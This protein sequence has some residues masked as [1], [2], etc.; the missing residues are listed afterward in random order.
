MGDVLQD[1]ILSGIDIVKQI[2]SFYTQVER[3]TEDVKL[4]S[5]WRSLANNKETHMGYLHKVLVYAKQGV[6]PQ[7]FSKPFEIKDELEDIKKNLGAFFDKSLHSNN[8]KDH[9]IAAYF[10]EFQ[11][12][13]TSFVAF[14]QLELPKTAKSM[15]GDQGAQIMRFIN[16]INNSTDKEPLFVLLGQSLQRL[17][18]YAL[19]VSEGGMNDTLTGI[20]SRQGFFHKIVSWLELMARDKKTMAIFILDIDQLK[21]INEEYSYKTGDKVLRFVAKQLNHLCRKSDL[22]GR[23]GGEEFIIFIPS[24]DKKNLETIADRYRK[25]I[26]SKSREAC[27]LNDE[28]V[29]VSIGAIYG[30]IKGKNIM[31]E[32]QNFI[33][34]AETLLSRKVKKNGGNGYALLKI[35]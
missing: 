6:I 33:D 34:S 19:I 32:F 17:W 31:Q 4:K 3:V 5:F 11:M 30:K 25:R 20:L 24:G 2:R 23:Y 26:E 7:V 28:S 27:L 16:L 35:D 18:D 9:F 10:A 8:V 22:L 1:I 21:R 13:H 29:T 12:T 14:F 15:S